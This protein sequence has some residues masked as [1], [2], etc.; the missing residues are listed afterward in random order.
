[1]AREYKVEQWVGILLLSALVA[2]ASFFSYSSAGEFPLADKV[3]IDLGHSSVVT[4]EKLYAHLTQDHFADLRQR[5]STVTAQV[6]L[7]VPGLRAVT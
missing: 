6:D 7:E 4:T 2:S 3:L 1:M 5:L